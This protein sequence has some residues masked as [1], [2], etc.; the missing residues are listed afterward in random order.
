MTP[1]NKGDLVI[2]PDG[3]YAIVSQIDPPTLAL[4]NGLEEQIDRVAFA[5]CVRMPLVG[6]QSSSPT[7]FVELVDGRLPSQMRRSHE[8]PTYEECLDQEPKDVQLA[9]KE[10]VE[11][12]GTTDA[13]WSILQAAG[14]ALADA[15]NELSRDKP[16]TEAMSEEDKAFY[17]RADSYVRILKRDLDEKLMEIGPDGVGG[18]LSGLT[19][20]ADEFDRRDDGDSPAAIECWAAMTAICDATFRMFGELGHPLHRLYSEGKRMPKMEH[21]FLNRYRCEECGESWARVW[22][23][24]CNDRCPGCRRET[25]PFRSDDIGED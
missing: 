18:L 23:H 5:Q 11:M 19:M 22:S 24:T 4:G 13:S 1:P 15:R 25:E 3:Y 16:E 9:I 17:M 20:Q 2:S 6:Q 12:A 14:R 10:I 21:R 7:N 8:M